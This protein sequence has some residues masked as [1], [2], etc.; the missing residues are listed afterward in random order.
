MDKYKC[1]AIT[2]LN[3][4]NDGIA[5]ELLTKASKMVQPIMI[6]H[7]LEI[8]TL[9][10][11][12]PSNPSLQG[13][14]TNK[15]EKVEIRCREPSDQHRFYT[16]DYIVGT[17]LHELCHNIHGPHNSE[18]YKLLDQFQNELDEFQS[19]NIEGTGAGF[20]MP[21]KV[22]DGQRHNPTKFEAKL[23][24]ADAAEKRLQLAQLMGKGKIG[25]TKTNLTPREAAALAAE[26]RFKDA[27]S[28]GTLQ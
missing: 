6:K 19:K 16:I 13:M 28:C 24:A 9:S 4:Q 8:I 10:E 15:G 25:G 2:T 23:K 7:K 12:F 22:L 17:L 26:R 21:G 11:F 14:N 27:T 18:F 3:W 5:K 20:D 1:Q